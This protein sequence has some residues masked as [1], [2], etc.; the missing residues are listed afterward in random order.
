MNYRG[1][2]YI[3]TSVMLISVCQRWWQ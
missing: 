1:S 3:I 2:S